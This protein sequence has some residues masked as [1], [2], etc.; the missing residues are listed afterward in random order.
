MP[1]VVA[2]ALRPAGKT[3]D[4]PDPVSEAGIEEERSRNRGATWSKPRRISDRE[5]GVGNARRP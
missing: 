4:K 1:V 5:R 2:Y 3:G